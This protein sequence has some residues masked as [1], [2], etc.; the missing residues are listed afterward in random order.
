MRKPF[1]KELFAT[2]DEL[3]RNAV[4][5]HLFMGGLLAEP[6]TDRY[7]IDLTVRK[8]E[9]RQ[10]LYGVECEI[11]R[12]WNGPVLPYA[13]IQ[14]PERKKKYL[15]N[16][17]PIEYWILN[18]TQTHAIIIPGHLV[19]QSEPV[20]VPNKYVRWGEKFYQIPVSECNLIELCRPAS[21]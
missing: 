6:H 3:A 9:S 21:E 15:N 1:S 14:L 2:N 17:W 13:T 11:K 7:G 12:V 4:I 20:I 19:E 18:S 5:Y 10:I 8:P 16:P